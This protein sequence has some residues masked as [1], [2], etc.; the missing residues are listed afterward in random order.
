MGVARRS[1]VILSLAV[2]GLVSSGVAWAQPIPPFPFP[3]PTPG[4]V[5]TPSPSA[6]PSVVFPPF[7]PALCVGKPQHLLIFD[8]KS[9]WWSGDGDQFH[10]LLLPRVVKDCPAIDIEYYFLQHIDLEGAP[11]P[12]GVQIGADGIMG[13][14]SFYPARPGIDGDQEFNLAAFPTRPWNE[15][16]QVW[17]LSGSNQDETD[18]PTDHEFFQK[19]LQKYLTPP[20]PPLTIPSLFIATGIGNRDHANRVLGILQLPELFQSHLSII[21]TPSVPDGSGV[22]LKGRATAGA[23]LTAHAIFEGVQS[24]PDVVGLAGAEYETD[25]LLEANN[26]FQIVGRTLKGEPAI[27]VRETPERRFVLDAG[28][29]RY[30]SMYKPEEVATY[31]YLQNIIKWLAR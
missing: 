4:P 2:I 26:P 25:Y 5:P 11:V 22:D 18:V 27:A 7:D 24:L 23:Q 8:M 17:I 10:N 15:Y 29:Q 14:V 13:V 6:P 16:H 21:D 20:T 9:G 12:P 30:Y 3:I 28:M 1:L 31:R 19:M